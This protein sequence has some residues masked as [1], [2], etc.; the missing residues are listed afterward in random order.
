VAKDHSE[1]LGE[2]LA[3]IAREK[4][5]IIK[6]GVPLLTCERDERLLSI[7]EEVCA[8]VGAPFSPL[9]I[10][11]RSMD[12][13][14]T[15]SHTCFTIKTRTWGPIRVR[16]PLVGEHQAINGAL[17]AAIVDGLPDSLRPDSRTVLDGIEGVHWPGRSQIVHLA[18]RTW[19]FDVAHNLAGAL[20][21]AAVL[22]RLSVP[23]PVVLLTAVLGDKDWRSILP[24]L[25]ERTDH[26]VFTQAPSAPT[27][28]RWDPREAALAVRCPDA[29]IRPDFGEALQRAKELAGAGTVV[30]TGSNHTVGDALA[31]L[32]L[33]PF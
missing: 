18:G 5:G 15:E 27:Q 33:S 12:L 9:R 21:L 14:I 20:A 2:S 29:E 13:E 1:H 24:P 31:A 28:R 25:L 10:D 8:R 19:V 6:A 30:V 11:P 32:D 22:D 26:A 7:F 4:A 23:R 16:T 3:E 17:A